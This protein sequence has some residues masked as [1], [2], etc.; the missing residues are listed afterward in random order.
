MST[1]P[2]LAERSMAIGLRALNRLAGS[3]AID[4]FGL[5]LPPERPVH[6]ASKTTRPAAAE[7]A[8]RIDGDQPLRPPTTRRAPA[9]R[10]LQDDDAH[11][12]HGR[13]VVH[14]RPAPVA[15]RPS[16]QGPP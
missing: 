2:N 4:R 8:G 10:R 16:A 14:G 3:T 6:G 15:S 11:R 7:P 5:R 13:T 1:P 9:S 12:R